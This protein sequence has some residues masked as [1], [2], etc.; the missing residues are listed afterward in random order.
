MCAV[1]EAT[2]RARKERLGVN[3]VK[4]RN[5]VAS[6]APSISA[7]PG[8]ISRLCPEPSGARGKIKS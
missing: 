3:N 1:A 6:G 5:L 8:F 2:Q 4:N 7:R